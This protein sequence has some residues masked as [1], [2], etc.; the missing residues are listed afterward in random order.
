M[1]EIQAYTGRLNNGATAPAVAEPI[2]PPPRYSLAELEQIASYV[3]QSRMFSGIK[4]PQQ[5]MTLMLLCEADR[6]H[7]MQA[8]RRY[9]VVDNR[10]PQMKA[11]VM[12]AEFQSAGGRVEWEER[13]ATRVVASFSHPIYHPK[14]VRIAWSIEDAERAGIFASNPNYRKYPRQMLTARVIGEGVRLTCPGVTNGIYTPEEMDDV[15]TVTVVDAAPVSA[16]TPAP[17]IAPPSSKP[18]PKR[19]D[20]VPPDTW[21][22]WIRGRLKAANEA[23]WAALRERGLSEA[24]AGEWGVVAKGSTLPRIINSLVTA[25]LE[26]GYVTQAGVGKDDDPAVRDADKAKKEVKRLY[27]TAPEWVRGKVE[28]WV[29]KWT[30]EAEAALGWTATDGPQDEPADGLDDETARSE[31]GPGADG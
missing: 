24:D 15:P 27:D 21:E 13:T 10:P 1:N 19:S 31:Y 2:P 28:A 5:A 20:S 8:V 6:L 3:V 11:D 18:Q 12:L 9:H 17:A 16:P 23:W 14:P 25:A 4:T 29:A 7:P 26:A 30:A 22:N